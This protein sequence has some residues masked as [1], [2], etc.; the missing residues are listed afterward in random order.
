MSRCTHQ[1]IHTYLTSYWSPEEQ[2]HVLHYT[3]R[4]RHCS[5]TLRPKPEAIEAI[6]KALCIRKP[7]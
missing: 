2:K 4:C 3:A 6:R 5:E 1:S 7:A